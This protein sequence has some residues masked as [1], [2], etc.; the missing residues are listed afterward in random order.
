MPDPE[1]DREELKIDS[2]LSDVDRLY[3]THLKQDVR[4]QYALIGLG[5]ASKK[6]QY[7]SDYFSHLTPEELEMQERYK[8]ED[9][10]ENNNYD[11]DE[12][13]DEYDNE[14]PEM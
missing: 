7:G 6:E 2:V 14:E 12:M 3:G 1:A 10:L 5:L 8:I 11:E 9:A 4:N 13:E